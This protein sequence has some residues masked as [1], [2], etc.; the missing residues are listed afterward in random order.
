MLSNHA[1][2][3]SSLIGE[4]GSSELLQAYRERYAIARPDRAEGRFAALWADWELEAICRFTVLPDSDTFRLITHGK[5]VPPPTYRGRPSAAVHA[6]VEQF[7]RSG[8]TVNFPRVEAYS[9]TVLALVREIEREFACHVRVHFFST[10]PRAQGLGLHAD[11]GDALILQV[12][13][14]KTWDVYHGS[15]RWTAAEAPARLKSTTPDTFTLETGGWLFVPTGVYHEVR[16]RGDEPSTHFTIGFH[17]LSWASGIEA[18]VQRARQ[19]SPAWRE[20]IPVLGGAPAAGEIVRRLELLPAFLAESMAAE[21][22]GVTLPA[23]EVVAR[24]RLEGI[25]RDTRFTWRRDAVA[26]EAR[27]DRCELSLAYRSVALR[28]RPELAAIL[29]RMESAGSFAPA[30][31]EAELPESLLLCR[32]LVHVGVLQFVGDS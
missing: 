32:F 18:A 12:Q 1:M 4:T 30:D 8:A 20:P 17:P 13:G 26:W 25:A 19:A 15:D 29:A 14:S 11:H 7:R 2:R 16:N 22:Y 6:A 5:Q 28:L 3:L 21:R 9:N 27:A 31:L 10:P 24:E 23:G